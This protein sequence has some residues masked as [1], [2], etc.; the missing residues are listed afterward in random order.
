M[1][2][3]DC[4]SLQELLLTQGFNT[5]RMCCLK[6]T[7]LNESLHASI[8]ELSKKNQETVSS[9]ITHLYTEGAKPAQKESGA[10]SIKHKRNYTFEKNT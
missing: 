1:Q 10:H 4:Q 7:Q 2:P 3:N 5:G 6:V 9:R 8:G